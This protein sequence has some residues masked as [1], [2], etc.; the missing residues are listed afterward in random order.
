[1]SNLKKNLLYNSIYQILLI[2]LPLLLSPYLSRVLG[3]E[4]IGTY[5]YTSSIAGTLALFGMLGVNNYGNRAIAAVRDDRKKRS[6]AFWNIW[7]WQVALTVMVLIL[8]IWYLFKLCRPQFRLVAAIEILMILNSMADINWLFFGL[9]EFRLTV[10][11]SAVI[12]VVSVLLIF[13]FVKRGQDLWIYA[14]IM[15]GSALFSNLVLWWFSGRYIDRKRPCWREAKTHISGLFL[16]FIPVIAVSVYQR[17]DKVMLGTLSDMKQSGYYENTEKLINIPKGLITA[18]GTVMLPRMSYLFA[19][20]KTDSVKGY[21]SRSM[22]FVMFSSSAMAFGIAAVAGDFVPLFFGKEFAPA[23]PMVRIMAC[24]IVFT[25][26]ANV[27]RTQYLIPAHRDKAYLVSVWAGAFVNFILNAVLI[28]RSGA[29]GAVI[30]TVAA[31]GCVMAV[32]MACVRKE[33]DIWGYFKRGCGYLLSGLVMY[34][35]VRAAAEEAGGWLEGG[36]LV[37]AEILTGA[38]VY[39]L[40]CAP[41]AWAVHRDGFR[42]T[43]KTRLKRR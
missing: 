21:L 6:T 37:A 3:A 20:G 28:P 25:A 23:G 33:L 15:A 17:M 38:A 39:V 27:I 13:L 40:L 43:V 18:L 7:F 2:I 9:E 31:E 8:Y 41:Y 34:L 36:P 22:E 14:F 5:S 26:C 19:M 4:G 11:R 30:G 35:T 12:K 16:L 1:M 29:K 10:S 24:C 32:Q 42:N